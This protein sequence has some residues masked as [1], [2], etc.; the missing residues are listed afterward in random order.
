[1]KM[2][3]EMYFGKCKY[4]DYKTDPNSNYEFVKKRTRDHIVFAHRDIVSQKLNES[5]MGCLGSRKNTRHILKGNIRDC[6]CIICGRDSANWKAGMLAAIEVFVNDPTKKL[7]DLWG[8][9]H[10]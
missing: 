7:S 2:T 5:T 6:R 8:I 4:C 3:M 1:M 9:H 10:K